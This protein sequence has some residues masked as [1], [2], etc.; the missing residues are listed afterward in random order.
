MSALTGA[1]RARLGIADVHTTLH[2]DATLEFFG[3]AHTRG[4]AALSLKRNTTRRDAAQPVANSQRP[5][6]HGTPEAILVE[7]DTS[8]RNNQ[9]ASSSTQGAPLFQRAWGWKEK[10][11]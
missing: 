2:P 5:E 7:A 4:I 3:H 6:V 8:P 1:S 9:T 11:H 10:L